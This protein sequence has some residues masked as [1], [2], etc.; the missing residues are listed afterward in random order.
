MALVPPTVVA[1]M[2]T[3]PVP[4]GEVVEQLVVVVQ[5]TAAVVVPNCRV[6]API[7][8]PLP[9]IVT[10]VPPANGPCVGLIPVMTG[11][12][13]TVWVSSAEGAP[14]LDTVWPVNTSLVEVPSE[15]VTVKVTVKGPP[16]V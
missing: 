1:V 15:S 10:A 14:S 11:A 4:A 12:M 9:L 13:L 7:T 3:V 5:V 6:V 2:A 16:V 8:N